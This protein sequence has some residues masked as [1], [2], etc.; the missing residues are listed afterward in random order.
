MYYA[1]GSQEYFQLFDRIEAESK[2][3]FQGKQLACISKLVFF[4]GVRQ[5][6]IPLIQ[7]RDVID[8]QFKIHNKIS[9]FS[10]EIHVCEPARAAIEIYLSDLKRRSPR[11]LLRKHAFFPS[12]RNV[13]KLKRDWKKFGTRYS[14]ILEAGHH[15]YYAEVMAR[16]QRPTAAFEFGGKQMR[17]TSRQFMAVVTGNKIS[18]GTSVETRSV[19][20]ILRLF[21][22][23]EFLKKD[24]P[25]V[26]ILAR[27]MMMEFEE[28][29]RSIRNEELRASYAKLRVRLEN[30]LSDYLS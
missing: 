16:G 15:H 17:V 6:E 28:N 24:D 21:E 7:V 18:A 3:R 27:G 14:E 8:H 5:K 4:C 9:K 29:L 10:K 2:D 26:K 25:D 13:E 20:N 12:Y 22:R 23:A 19:T 30:T 1:G 11:Y